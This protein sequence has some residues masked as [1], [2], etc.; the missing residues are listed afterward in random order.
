MKDDPDFMS[1]LRWLTCKKAN[2]MDD[3]DYFKKLDSILPVKE[4]QSMEARAKEMVRAMKWVKQKGLEL[5]LELA[6]V[7]RTS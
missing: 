1:A 3:I 4:G 5:G 6:L 7:S 2:R